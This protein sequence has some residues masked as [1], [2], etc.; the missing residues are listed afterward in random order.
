MFGL[1]IITKGIK[2]KLTKLVW[3]GIYHKCTLALKEV[4]LQ[5]FVSCFVNN[6]C[7]FNVSKQS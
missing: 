1:H 4:H 2:Q 3:R 6:T 7:N 5:S